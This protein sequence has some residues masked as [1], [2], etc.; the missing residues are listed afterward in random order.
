[1]LEDEQ[2]D[3]PSVQNPKF[4]KRIAALADYSKKKIQSG[5]IDI[6]ARVRDFHAKNAIDAVLE[7]PDR[8]KENGKKPE[9][10]VR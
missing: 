6:T 2:S 10:L 3:V 8:F 5:A 4:S 1:M 9:Q 7:A